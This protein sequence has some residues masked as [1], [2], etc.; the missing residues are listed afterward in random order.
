MGSGEIGLLAVNLALL[1]AA[2][3]FFRAEKRR[4]EDTVSRLKLWLAQGLGLGRIPAA[5]G[6]FGSVL[7]V[8]W[9]AVLLASGRWWVFLAGTVAG[10]GVSVWLSSAAERILGRK[11]PGGVVVD[12]VAA[13]P[14]CFLPWVMVAL[15]YSRALPEPEFFLSARTWPVTVGIFAAFRLFDVVKPWPVRQ[16]QA[17]A[18]GWG[19]TVDDLLA[20][21][22]VAV[23]WLAA[24]AAGAPVQGS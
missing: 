22:Y 21:V 20:A 14:V 19:I 2:N 9:F 1:V 12:E 15:H 7:G 6:T 10:L 17:L 3:L 11:D 23:A 8:A 4:G 13:V 24:F 5:P 18:G 16:S